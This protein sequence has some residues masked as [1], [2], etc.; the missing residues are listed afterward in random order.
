MEVIRFSCDECEMQ[1]TGACEDCVVSFIC[2]REPEDALIVNAD[3][4][5]AMRMLGRAGLLPPLRHRRRTG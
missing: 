1:D 2:G 5:R 4:E 3:E